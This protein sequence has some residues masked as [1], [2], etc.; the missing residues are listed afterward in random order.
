MRSSGVRNCDK[1]ASRLVAV[2][3]PSEGCPES[4]DGR[5]GEADRS[6]VERLFSRRRFLAGGAAALVSVGA[7]C[8]TD[9]TKAS[10]RTTARLGG[11]AKKPARSADE[12]ELP[13]AGWIQ[14]ENRL[15]GTNAWVV[16]SVPIPHSIEGYP[17]H[18]SAKAGDTVA[19]HVSSTAPT[20]H[21]EA[22]RMGWY[23]GY[24]GRLVWRSPETAGQ[25]QPIPGPQSSTNMVECNWAPSLH[26][27][28]KSD[29]PAG[30][31]LLKLVGSNGQQKLMPFIV[32][33]DS[34]TSAI[35]VQNS[36]TT[37]QAYN[38]WGGYSLYYG[39]SGSGQSYDTRSRVVSFDRPYGLAA[40]DWAD[41]AGDWLGN[42]YPFVM[43][44]E[45][46]GLDVTYWSD[47]DFAANPDLLTRHKLLVSLGHDEYWSSSMFDGALRARAAGVNFA[48]LGANACF[49]HIRVQDSPIGSNRQVVCYK[50]ESEDP[51]YGIDNSEVT[52]DWPSGP[53][54]R[55]E[56]VLIG[57]MYQSNPVDASLVASDASGW[58]LRGTG[59][60][61]GDSLP[62]VI[63]SEYDAYQ[64]GLA[65][66]PANLEIWA[67]S[68]LVCR[69]E[70]GFADMTYYT[71]PGAGGVFATGTNWWVNKLSANVGRVSSGVVFDAIPEVTGAL[72]RITTNVLGVLGNGP[73]GKLR[74]SVPNWK[75]HY[76]PGATSGPPGGVQGA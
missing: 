18:V 45:K 61:A 56:C 11:A 58:G 72:T 24:G 30:N 55:P 59:M 62:H 48:F 71:E 70:P 2:T 5:V 52:A 37:W 4:T 47:L 17:D 19:L 68:P 39:V 9:Q 3:T 73:G 46:L 40:E 34:S 41:G 15:P 49:R 36:V 60:R 75:L 65:G 64:P 66:T 33:D 63:G 42:D 27:D 20:F 21:V 35:V 53:V 44:A 54:P 50:D 29:W 25:T 22:Y 14:A 31:Y 6:P 74:P 28:V 12:L 67:H 26:F 23:Q 32:R 16:G 51:L 38:L 43:L 57:S 7:A 76:P 1:V 10:T 69:G 13:T 8:G